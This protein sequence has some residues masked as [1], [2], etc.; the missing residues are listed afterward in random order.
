MI[1]FLFCGCLC[2][3]VLSVYCSLVVAC[4]E[5]ADL[6]ALMCE[7]F[8]FAFDPLRY[9]GSG[10]FVILSIPNLCLLPYCYT[11]QLR[12]LRRSK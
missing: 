8:S 3:I 4:W 11:L 5:S 2:Q 1:I 10:V 9:P 7:M 12:V 6:L